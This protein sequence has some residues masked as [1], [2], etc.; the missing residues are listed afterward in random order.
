VFDLR[1]AG[2]RLTVTTAARAD[3]EVVIEHEGRSLVVRDDEVRPGPDLRG[4]GLWLSLVC[5][6]P[7]EHWTIGLEAFA[8]AVDHPDD[9]RGELVPLGLDVEWEAPGRLHGEL[10]VGAERYELDVP[11][12]LTVVAEKGVSRSGRRGRGS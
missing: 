2:G 6:T 5:E 9:E 11:A 3:V 7:G 12:E 1:W 10:L 8:L 4:P